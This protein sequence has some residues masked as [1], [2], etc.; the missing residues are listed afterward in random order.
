MKRY[1]FIEHT[2][3]IVIKA[4]GQNLEEAFATAAEAMFDLLTGEALR[5]RKQKIELEIQSID[6]EGLLVGFLSKL[7]VFHEVDGLVFGGFDVTFTGNDS[8]KATAWGEKFNGAKHGGGI[9]VKA[10][11]YHMIEVVGGK[12][13][14]PSYVQVLFDV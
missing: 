2:A 5:E 11:T 12:G 8:L 7:I 6:R 3:D 14:S 10:V 1:E 4:Y 13:K 9:S